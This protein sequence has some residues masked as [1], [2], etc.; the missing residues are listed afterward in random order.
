MVPDFTCSGLYVRSPLHACRRVQASMLAHLPVRQVLAATTATQALT[1]LGVLALAAV[2][3]RAAADLG[4]PP[5]LIGYQVSVSYGAAMFAA[6][7]GGGLVRRLG[8][9]L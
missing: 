6:L 3:P 2:A 5:G 9:T 7:L 8:A 1:T 4:L